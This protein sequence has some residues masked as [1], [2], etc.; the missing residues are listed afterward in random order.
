MYTVPKLETYSGDELERAVADL[1]S[2]LEAEV[3]SVTNDAQWQDFRNR[4]TARKNGILTQINDGWLKA[5]PGPQKRDVG[6]RV[7]Q[8]KQKVEAVVEETKDSLSGSS[9]EKRLAAER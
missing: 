4:W 9:N 7:N 1:L 8:V 6:Q 5:A 3:P 2:A